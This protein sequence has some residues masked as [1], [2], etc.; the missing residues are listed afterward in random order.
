MGDRITVL[1]TISP[2]IE[3]DNQS[4][5]NTGI[6]SLIMYP[7]YYSIRFQPLPDLNEAS[8][9]NKLTNLLSPDE[10]LYCLKCHEI[11]SFHLREVKFDNN[12][13]SNIVLNFAKYDSKEYVLPNDKMSSCSYFF[14]QLLIHGIAAPQ[15]N[16][17]NAFELKFYANNHYHSTFTVP[18]HLQLFHPRFTSLD[19]FWNGVVDFYRE[20]ITFLFESKNL[21]RDQ[22]YPLGFATNSLLTFK[23]NSVNEFI[24]NL[25]SYEKVIFDN[26]NILFDSNGTLIDQELFKNRLFYSG[27]DDKALPAVLPFAVGVYPLGSTYEERKEIDNK[28]KIDF[29]KL[30]DQ[31]STISKKQIRC[32]KKL[33]ESLRVINQDADRTDRLQNAF[34]NPKKPGLFMLTSLLKCYCMYNQRIGYLQGMNDM[35]VPLILSFVPEWS[36]DGD[37]IDHNGQ[38]ISKEVLL[39]DYLPRIFFCYVSIIKLTGHAKLLSNVTERSNQISHLMIAIVSK[40]EPLIGIWLAQ[41]NLSE[42]LWMYSDFIYI[43][44]RSFTSKRQNIWDAWLQMLCFPSPHEWLFYFA[45]AVL[46]EVFHNIFLMPDLSMPVLMDTYPKILLSL[47]VRTIGNKALYLYQNCRLTE[48]EYKLIV[49]DVYG[50]AENFSIKDEEE[51]APDFESYN[52]EFCEFDK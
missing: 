25:P 7:P 11:S 33:R 46:L 5:K 16:K 22:K 21:P 31:V 15:I 18:S 6:L 51:E 1:S 50:V 48:N 19:D 17:E 3:I 28:M 40:F 12:D 4:N 14:Q 45:S 37:P 24:S 47:D 49:S 44:K 20:Y 27:C 32:H 43:Y 52:F 38:I 2:V 41:N 23:E 9:C 35:F 26:L 34:K 39:S 13:K 42:F 8:F 10:T 29:K 36:S 30:Y